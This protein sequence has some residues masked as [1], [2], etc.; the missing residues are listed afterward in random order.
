MLYI[1]QPIQTGYSYGSLINGTL[2]LL[3]GTLAPLEAGSTFNDTVLL[4]TIPNQDS[5]GTTQGSKRGAVAIWH[6]MQVWANQYVHL[7]S[8]LKYP[9]LT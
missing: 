3:D 8:A 6:F 9:M 4:G 5:L 1:D 7:F 2:D